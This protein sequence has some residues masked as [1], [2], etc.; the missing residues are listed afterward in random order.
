MQSAGSFMLETIIPEFMARH[1]GVQLDLVVEGRLVDIVEQGFDA[2]VRLAEAV[3]KDMVAVPLGPDI[4]FVA[5]AAPLYLKD[6]PAPNTPDELARHHC[7]RQRLPSGKRYRWEFRRRQQEL[8]VDAPGTLTLDNNQ[9][10]V[11]A[12][13]AGLGIAYIPESFATGALQDGRL[14]TVLDDWCPCIPGLRL[15]FPANR[16]MPPS[17]RAFIDVIRGD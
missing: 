6:H 12:A 9:L 7:I 13:V 17:L 3:P 14:Q 2:G 1:P 15:Y 5:V 10:M 8:S 4:R 16:H 11:D